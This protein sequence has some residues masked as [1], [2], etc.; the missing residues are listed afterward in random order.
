MKAARKPESA[1]S[2]TVAQRML[3]FCIASDTDWKKAGVTGA[4]VMGMLVKGL[5]DR[6]AAGR[7]TLT[8]QG[9][10]ALAWLL[11]DRS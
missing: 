4:V 1:R 5:I 11:K 7:L 10:A 3:L 6:D 9:R 2:L 8:E